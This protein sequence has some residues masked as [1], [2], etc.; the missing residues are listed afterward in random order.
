M[1]PSLTDEDDESEPTSTMSD[2]HGN[3]FLCNVSMNRIEGKLESGSFEG[4]IAEAFEIFILLQK[5]GEL[6]EGAKHNMKTSFTT[7]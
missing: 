4:N 5:L 3:N 2:R 7:D 6:P 1:Y